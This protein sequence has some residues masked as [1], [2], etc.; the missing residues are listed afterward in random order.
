MAYHRAVLN[1]IESYIEHGL[2]ESDLD[3][4]AQSPT[5][6]NVAPVMRRITGV[7]QQGFLHIG[8][9]GYVRGMFKGKGWYGR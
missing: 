4:Q 8:Q 5:L 7:I 6:N 1:R 3:R 9:A 2:T